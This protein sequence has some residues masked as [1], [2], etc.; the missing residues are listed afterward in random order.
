MSPSFLGPSDLERRVW[1]SQGRALRN[2]G[3]PLLILELNSS[4]PSTSAHFFGTEVAV[5]VRP[6]G[7]DLLGA[8][9]ELLCDMRVCVEEQVGIG[10]PS[11]SVPLEKAAV[12]LEVR[13]ETQAGSSSLTRY[14]NKK[15][16]FEVHERRNSEPLIACSCSHR[17][18]VAEDQC[19]FKSS[20]Q[21]RMGYAARSRLDARSMSLDSL[22]YVHKDCC[23]S[24]ASCRRVEGLCCSQL[25]STCGP[26]ETDGCCQEASFQSGGWETGFPRRTEGFSSAA[27]R[28]AGE[29]PSLDQERPGT[30]RICLPTAFTSCLHCTCAYSARLEAGTQDRVNFSSAFCQNSVLS[31]LERLNKRSKGRCLRMPCQ[32]ST[33]SKPSLAH[34]TS[35]GEATASDS[36]VAHKKERS[37]VLVRRYLKNNQKVLKKVCTGTR[38]IMRTGHIS[39][40][41]WRAM[42][43]RRCHLSKACNS[44]DTEYSRV[45][46]AIQLQVS[47][48]LLSYSG[49]RLQQVGLFFLH[50]IGCRINGSFV[51]RVL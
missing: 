18:H 1:R 26:V 4:S 13:M 37:T 45:L 44:V 10:L 46:Q 27:T 24:T 11:I 20:K 17:L 14:R 3:V 19:D 6:S 48:A 12:L 2:L 31:T 50:I 25:C 8:G 30:R 41:A 51:V 40:G 33:T 42:Y 5:R 7:T 22:D 21:I 15:L 36:E 34:Q 47:R 23:C 49:V 39:D 9:I 35:D 43:R 16:S 28:L 29:P 38:A 32:A